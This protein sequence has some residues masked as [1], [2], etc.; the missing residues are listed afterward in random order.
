MLRRATSGSRTLRSRSSGRATTRSAPTSSSPTTSVR[1]CCAR[2]PSRISSR[3]TGRRSPSS[4]RGRTARS[5]PLWRSVKRKYNP[6]VAEIL[7]EAAVVKER[8][9]W[10]D[11]RIPTRVGWLQR[12]MEPTPHFVVYDEQ[13]NFDRPRQ[14]RD[15]GAGPRSAGVPAGARQGAQR[16]A[17]RRSHRPGVRAQA[18]R[19]RRPLHRAR[20]RDRLGQ[21]VGQHP[22]RRRLGA[23]IDAQPAARDPGPQRAALPVRV[24]GNRRV[25]VDAVRAA[26][27]IP[28]RGPPRHSPEA[29]R[30]DLADR[31]GPA[32]GTLRRPRRRDLRRRARPRR[33]PRPRR[34]ADTARTRAGSMSRASPPAPASTSRR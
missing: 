4:T 7:T 29:A 28:R 6:G 2:S 13:A 17:D 33:P 22:R 3:P 26:D 12:E 25:R 16:P 14:A 19:A 30:V 24:T 8:T 23:R 11:A 20:R 5:S 1:P 31:G 15:A 21:R 18:V 27:P 9:G 10:E 34:R 32:G